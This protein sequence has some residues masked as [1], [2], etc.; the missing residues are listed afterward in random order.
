[1]SRFLLSKKAQALFLVNTCS[2][3]GVASEEHHTLM[4]VKLRITELTNTLE[5]QKHRTEN[6]GSYIGI[7]GMI[8]KVEIITF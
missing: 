4:K 8:H 3:E 2:V 7:L 1:M 5:S 6:K